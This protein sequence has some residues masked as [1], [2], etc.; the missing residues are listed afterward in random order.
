[1]VP[2]L[3]HARRD[4]RK[5]VPVQPGTRTLITLLVVYTV[6]MLSHVEILVAVISYDFSTNYHACIAMST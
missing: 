2:A 6:N 4:C 1:M 5:P 3:L